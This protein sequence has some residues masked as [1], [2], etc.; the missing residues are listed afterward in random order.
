M[1]VGMAR[2]AVT[3]AAVAH[4]RRNEVQL[5]VPHPTLAHGL[6]GEGAHAANLAAQYGDF[7]AAFVV[8]MHVQ[9]RDLE[10]VVLVL[11]FGQAPAE[12]AAL[13][14]HDGVTIE[15]RLDFIRADYGDVVTAERSL[16][17]D[18][19]QAASLVDSILDGP[20]TVLAGRPLTGRQAFA[21]AS[22]VRLWFDGVRVQVRPSGTE[23]KVK[24]YAEGI[25]TD[26]APLLDALA[27]L[28]TRQAGEPN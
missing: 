9:G 10:V 27:G 20:P 25:G 11:A 16:R 24:L 4:R 21:E 17:M 3:V 28:V 19:R 8:E 5:A 2:P 1:V 14:A 6:I 12:I 26:P 22:L 7:Q 23:P 15:D 13:A 18:P